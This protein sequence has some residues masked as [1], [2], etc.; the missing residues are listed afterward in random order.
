M[1]SNV[2]FQG[3]LSDQTSGRPTPLVAIL[4]LNFNSTKMSESCLASLS[5]IDY[6]NYRIILIDNGSDDCSI[7]EIV[8]NY[9][10]VMFIDLET[11]LGFAMG[12]NIGLTKALGLGADYCLLLNNDTEVAPDFL[13]RLVDTMESDPAIAITGP[14]IYYS[15]APEVIWSAGGSINT[16]LGTTKMLGIGQIDRGQYGSR[17]RQVDY[18]TGC[19]MGVR[20]SILNQV[21]MLDPRFFMYYEEVEWCSR[22]KKMNHLVVHVPSSKVWHKISIEER[23]RSH[24]VYYYMTRNRLLFLEQ[25][26]FGW[27]AWLHTLL[28]DYARTLLSWTIKPKWRNKRSLRRV[29]AR[30]ILDY[31]L[32]RFGKASNAYL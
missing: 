22:I 2:G 1:D 23:E 29:M 12:N 7:E 11:N 28:F 10:E 15:D 19:A 20:A 9:P 16:R 25:A 5:R 30:A 31:Y 26:G 6:P 8:S 18:V 17:P 13:T 4:V 14:M 27:L 3:E 24:L 32:K 21:G